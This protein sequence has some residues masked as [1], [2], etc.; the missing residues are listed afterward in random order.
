V[1]AAMSPVREP[2]GIVA[3]ARCGP[4]SID[5]VLASPPQLVVIVAAVQDPGN[6]GAI[7]RTAEACGATGVITTAG[8][9]NAFGWKAL[10]GS[11][12]SAFRMPIATQPSV[13]DAVRASR[14]AG[15]RVFATVIRDGTPLP[16][17]ALSGPSAIVLGGEGSGLDDEVVAAADERLT[18]PMKAPV[19]S[20]NVAS[21]AALIVYEAARQR[22]RRR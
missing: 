19:D 21:A 18:I 4:G 13:L 14:A 8:S 11:M 1:L 12:G 7:V 16:S 20:L 3:I 22:A 2:A 6:V 15:L 5:R 9:A 17:T 10:R